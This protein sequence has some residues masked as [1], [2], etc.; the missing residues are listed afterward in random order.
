MNDPSNQVEAYKARYGKQE[1]AEELAADLCRALAEQYSQ[2]FCVGFH[3]RNVFDTT[4]PSIGI[5][6][7]PDEAYDAVKEI[8]KKSSQFGLQTLNHVLDTLYYKKEESNTTKKIAIKVTYN[9]KGHEKGHCH[10]FDR[11]EDKIEKN[12]WESLSYGVKKGTFD[13]RDLLNV[14]DFTSG[15]LAKAPCLD[16]ATIESTAQVVS[17]GKTKLLFSDYTCGSEKLCSD[18]DIDHSLSA[19]RV[20]TAALYQLGRYACIEYEDASEIKCL[21]PE[22]LTLLIRPGDP[23]STVTGLTIIGNEINPET[24]KKAAKFLE[25]CHEEINTNDQS[26]E[27]QE[28][29]WTELLLHDRGEASEKDPLLKQL[30]LESTLSEGL[31]LPI[32]QS[33]AA[34]LYNIA[35]QACGERLEGQK[36]CFGFLLGNPGLMTHTPREQPFP[37]TFKSGEDVK[38]L[39]IKAL[40]KQVHLV[41]RPAERAIV[42]PY[43]TY[44]PKKE[45]NRLFIAPHLLEFDEALEEFR[46]RPWSTLWNAEYLPYLYYTERFPWAVAAYVGPG[47]E[48]RVFSG[49]D[50]VGFHDEKGWGGTSENALLPFQLLI[51]ELNKHPNAP[52]EIAQGIVNI[53][54]QMSPH[55]NPKA[56]G[57]MLVYLAKTSPGDEQN[58]AKDTPKKD[59]YSELFSSLN[60]TDSERFDG[61]PWLTGRR[62]MEETEAGGFTL[63]YSVA[64]MILQAAM[65]DGA[66]ILEYVQKNG[67]EGDKEKKGGYVR[68]KAF[69]Q[70]ILVGEQSGTEAKTEADQGTRRAA[71]RN[72]MASDEIPRGSIAIAISSDGPFRV[73]YK[74]QTG[75]VKEATATH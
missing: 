34:F 75:N 46:A 73:W 23:Y 20:I 30:R 48:I 59:K 1:K 21:G 2:P 51:Q 3:I 32:K 69:A 11:I 5:K 53:A 68:V 18:L 63:D 54:V 38:F 47:A 55:A 7:S 31:N 10:S 56:K 16:R 57:G 19:Y 15:K 8:K 66:I 28:A 62:L 40:L 6:A 52:L 41:S 74:M 39:N 65:L 67:K 17:S 36:I 25:E 13:D 12:G 4:S 45:D 43:V 70:R 14:G 72:L 64:K 22:T 44:R 50:L 35:R 37:L 26:T 9:W 29:E 61:Q 71:A 33:F 24:V 60:N 42:I 58:S 27:N 49:G